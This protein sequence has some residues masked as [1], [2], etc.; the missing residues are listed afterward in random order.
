MHE[1][2]AGADL[3]EEVEGG[4]LAQIPLFADEVEQVAFACVFQCQVD[5]VLVLEAC[6]EA[7]DVL[8]VELLLNSNFA[9]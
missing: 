5:G 6:V 8:V 4:V 2:D 7:A 3:D 9:N 1:V